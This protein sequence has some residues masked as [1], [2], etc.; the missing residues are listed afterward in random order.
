[1]TMHNQTKTYPAYLEC[2]DVRWFKF[3]VPRTGEKIWCPSC[4]EYVTVGMP[5]SVETLGF[6]PDYMWSCT[7][8]VKLYYGKCETGDCDYTTRHHDWFKLKPLM[9]THHLRAHSTSALITRAIEV[10]K[11]LPRNSPPPF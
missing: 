8:K 5:A 6:Y 2:G 7:R 4:D 3:A 9:E 10:P 1:M 11:P